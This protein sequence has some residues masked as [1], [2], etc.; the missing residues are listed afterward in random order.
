MRS[1]HLRAVHHSNSAS[2]VPHSGGRLL[3]KVDRGGSNSHNHCGKSE[4]VLLEK[5][6]VL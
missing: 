4:A 2:E 6:N 1:R 3:H 5:D